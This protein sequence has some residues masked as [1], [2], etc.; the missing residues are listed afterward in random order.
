[1]QQ[2]VARTIL[3]GPADGFS[4][5]IPPKGQVLLSGH[6]QS[7]MNAAAEGLYIVQVKVSVQHAGGEPVRMAIK[8]DDATAAHF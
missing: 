5:A 1:M 2:T 3:T 6:L 8:L 7:A 4:V